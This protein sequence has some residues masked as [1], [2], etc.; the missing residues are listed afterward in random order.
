[1]GFLFVCGLVLVPR[2]PIPP[3]QGCLQALF[4]CA[5]LVTRLQRWGAGGNPR[6][7]AG[8]GAQLCVTLTLSKAALSLTIHPLPLICVPQAGTSWGS[9]KI[10]ALFLSPSQPLDT[11]ASSQVHCHFLQRAFLEFYFGGQ[12]FSPAREKKCQMNDCV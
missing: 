11:S 8:W 7:L 4:R 3:L 12:A 10:P 9:L 5:E 1:M 6:L 2:R